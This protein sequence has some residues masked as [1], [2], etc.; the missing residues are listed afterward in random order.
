MPLTANQRLFEYQILRELGSGGFATVYLAH[1]TLLDRPVAIKELKF[2]DETTEEEDILWFLQ[3]A[4]VAGGLNHPHIVTVYALR[5]V[6]PKTHYLIMEYLGAGS[7]RDYMEQHKPLAT[8]VALRIATDVCEGLAAAHAQGIVHRDIKPENIL[9]TDAKRAKISDF[10]LAHVPLRAGGIQ[11]LTGDTGSQPGTVTY[12]SPEQIKGQKIDGR[13][14][15]YQVGAML[16]EMLAGQHYIDLNAIEQQAQR[17]VGDDASAAFAYALELLTDAICEGH[18]PDIR[19][20][21]PDTPIWVSEILAVTLA[22]EP[23]L[24]PTAGEVAHRLYSQIHKSSDAPQAAREHDDEPERIAAVQPLGSG[25]RKSLL[26]RLG[27]KQSLIRRH[28]NKA[29][30]YTQRRQLEEAV[31]EYQAILRLTPSDPKAHLSLGDCYYKQGHLDKASHEYQTALRLKPENAKG[32][33]RLGLIYKQLA[34]WDRALMAF[35]NAVR[36]APEHPR[37]HYF[38][39]M[40]YH[41]QR[42]QPEAI[43]EYKIALRL[44]PNLPEARTN[45]G[46]AYSQQG[47]WEDAVYEYQIALS[48]KPEYAEAHYLLSVAYEE[49]NRESEAK[50]ERLTAKKL[51]F[52]LLNWPINW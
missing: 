34:Q 44:K 14:D 41:A 39:G 17:S 15:V 21:R 1:D 9:L 23:P 3:E 26:E 18:A 47:R 7:L 37:A 10:G 12:M 45:L 52:Q 50:Q 8:P 30:A 38:L 49:L 11:G 43:R 33:Y 36:F 35:Q 28:Y 42:R 32:Y 27:L 20:T 31:K 6:A 22:K 25:K 19:A 48:L 2:T 24:R 51:G 13:S 29:V 40:A 4:R 5:I 46:L 16:Y